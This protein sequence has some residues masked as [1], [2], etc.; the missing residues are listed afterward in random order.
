M[1][2][3]VVV[4]DLPVLVGLAAI[5]RWG[6][7]E[8][9]P[10]WPTPDPNEARSYATV[11]RRY[12]WYVTVASVSGLASGIPVAGAGGRLGMR[13]L[14]ATAGDAAHGR[15]TEADEVVGRIT[16]GGGWTRA[17]RAGRD[18]RRTVGEAGRVGPSL[19]P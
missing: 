11:A 4:C 15:I 1:A 17:P 9:K 8:P 2:G 7:L 14:A 13:L 5:V 10:P 12:I 16:I 6:E 3:V 19:I 18:T